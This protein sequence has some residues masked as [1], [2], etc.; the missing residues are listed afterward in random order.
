MVVMVGLSR[1]EGVQAV[2]DARIR[3][4]I[5]ESVEEWERRADPGEKR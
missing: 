5:G 3:E 2:P 1:Y 4:L